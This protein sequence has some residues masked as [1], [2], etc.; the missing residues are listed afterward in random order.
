M[1]PMWDPSVTGSSL[2]HY[3]AMPVPSEYF[4]NDMSLVIFS[5]PLT[6]GPKLKLVF[7]ILLFIFHVPHLMEVFS[8]T[9][10]FSMR[11]YS[12]LVSCMPYPTGLSKNKKLIVRCYSGFVNPTKVWQWCWVCRGCFLGLVRVCSFVP[13]QLTR[14][15]KANTLPKDFRHHT[16]MHTRAHTPTYTLNHVIFLKY[17]ESRMKCVCKQKARFPLSVVFLAPGDGKH[18][19]RYFLGFLSFFRVH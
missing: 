1:A 11:L 2:T 7:V 19:F 15:A 4:K 8:K 18:N 12:Q 9:T 16:H 14:G 13:W 5:L 6:S 17:S 10:H 3:I